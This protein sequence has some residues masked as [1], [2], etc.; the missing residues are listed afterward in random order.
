MKNFKK[1]IVPMVG[2]LTILGFLIGGVYA[3]ED[4]YLRTDI[5]EQQMSSIT[6]Q[7]E[8]VGQRLDGKIEL[9]RWYRNQAALRAYGAII[10]QDC[11][12]HQGRAKAICINLF[13]QRA[14]VEQRLRLMGI[15]VPR[16]IQ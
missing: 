8:L 1:F 10:P 4:R 9:D 2:I 13:R 11:N 15:P 5:A 16:I 6:S 14:D 7:V 3:I 12:R